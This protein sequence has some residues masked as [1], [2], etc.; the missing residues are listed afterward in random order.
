[1]INT[2]EKKGKVLE[3]LIQE[4][5]LDIINKV[6]LEEDLRLGLLHIIHHR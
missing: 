2:K 3:A 1:L 6:P 4:E 5:A